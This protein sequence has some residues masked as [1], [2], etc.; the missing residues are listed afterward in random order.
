MIKKIKRNTKAKKIIWDF[1]LDHAGKKFYLTQIAVKTKISDSTAQQILEK[2]TKEGLLKKVKLGN[3]SFYVLAEN[4]LV[5]Q[6]KILRTLEL[7]EPLVNQL[8]EVC[9]KIILYGSQ[10]A[11]EGTSKSD[12]DLLIISHQKDKVY[13]IFSRAKIKNK[14]NL[15]VKNFLEWTQLKQKDKFFS[16]EVEKGKVLWES[17]ES[18]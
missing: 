11:G 1:L 17:N 8:K 3:L 2:K 13:K 9:Q 12:I 4:P 10:A 15:L 14:V 7:I 6:E 18:I 16:R 5:K